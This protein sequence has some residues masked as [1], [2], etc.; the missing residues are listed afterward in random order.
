MRWP[1]V[2]HRWEV[3]CDAGKPS[4]VCRVCGQVS[5]IPLPAEKHGSSPLCPPLPFPPPPSEHGRTGTARKA[6]QRW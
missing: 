4:R 5:G 6:S 3:R 1:H 2:I